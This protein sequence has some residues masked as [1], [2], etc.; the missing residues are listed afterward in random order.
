MKIF[1]LLEDDTIGRVDQKTYKSPDK[2][3]GKRVIAAATYLTDIDLFRMVFGTKYPPRRILEFKPPFYS[4]KTGDELEI[5]GPQEKKMPIK[6]R[7]E[8]RKK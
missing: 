8:S 4:I 6:R 3:K 7:K 5:M 1:L 2:F